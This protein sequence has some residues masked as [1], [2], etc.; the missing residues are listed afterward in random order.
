MKTTE[1]E[2]I[3]I[4]SAL[5]KKKIKLEKKKKKKKKKKVS[6]KNN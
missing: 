6:Y 3:W 1:I 2:K 4:S 5:D